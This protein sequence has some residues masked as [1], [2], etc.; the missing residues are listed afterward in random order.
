MDGRDICW[1]LAG[2]H[3]AVFIII[4][5]NLKFN[6]VFWFF[7]IFIIIWHTLAVYYTSRKEKQRD[8]SDGKEGGEE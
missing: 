4:L 6:F 1:Y 2:F 5:N 7:G 8:V 3:L